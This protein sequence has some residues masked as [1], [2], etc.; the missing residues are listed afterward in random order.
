VVPA[1][2]MTFDLLDGGQAAAHVAEVEALQAEV[3]GGVPGGRADISAQAPGEFRAQVRQPGFVLAEARSG[4]YLI[5]CAAGLPLRPST[6]WW[7]HLTA[8]LPEDIIAERP[9]RTFALVEL[10]VRASW[11]RQGI[12]RYLH[13]LIL[14]GRAEE[15]A[16]LVVPPAAGPAQTAFQEW[17]WHRIARTRG[18]DPG[19]P[20]SDVLVIRLS[21]GTD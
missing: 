4:G 5:G 20:A 13:D 9:G 21:A 2:E 18:P 6:S 8:A 16:T 11:R 3:Y 7:R 14:R 19:S 12:G 1:P 15:R 17:G 10:M